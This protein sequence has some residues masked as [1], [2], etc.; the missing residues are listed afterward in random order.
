MKFLSIFGSREEEKENE[1]LKAEQAKP[2]S[3][4]VI[5]VDGKEIQLGPNEPYGFDGPYGFNMTSKYLADSRLESS[6][7]RGFFVDAEGIT[8]PVHTITRAFVR[9]FV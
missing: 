9:N 1:W 7:R 4:I 6:Y 5:V 3:T 8:Y 2:R